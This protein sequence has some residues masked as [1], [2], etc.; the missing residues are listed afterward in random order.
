ME[1][2]ISL[3]LLMEMCIY[4][5]VLKMDE[6]SLFLSKFS[7]IPQ[8]FEFQVSLVETNTQCWLQIKVLYILLE[9]KM[10]KGSLVMGIENQEAFLN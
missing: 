9:S 7:S 6:K 4:G 10:R 2:K 3:Q 5:L 1:I 8:R